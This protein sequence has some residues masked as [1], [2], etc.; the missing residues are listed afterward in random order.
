MER[1]SYIECRICNQNSNGFSCIM[2]D[3]PPE[4]LTLILDWNNFQNNIEFS[5]DLN[6]DLF[7]YLYKWENQNDQNAKY[8]LIGMLTKYPNENINHCSIFKSSTDNNW[9]CYKNFN[10]SNID[11]ISNI[12]K[13]KPYL[14]F[15]QKI[16][17]L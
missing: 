13:G 15:Y 11:K 10:L 9:K 17:Y 7:K 6:I 8:E 3:S 1:Q 16:E 4:I 5:I 2:I 14:L 12:D